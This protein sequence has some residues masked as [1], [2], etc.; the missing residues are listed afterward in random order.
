MS[1]DHAWRRDSFNGWRYEAENEGE[2]MVSIEDVMCFTSETMDF[3][4]A[5]RE[6][7]S[8]LKKSRK[9]IDAQLVARNQSNTDTDR[10]CHSISEQQ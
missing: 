2:V 8:A 1:L 7:S 4:A 5:C 6:R 3:G 10:A 9:Q